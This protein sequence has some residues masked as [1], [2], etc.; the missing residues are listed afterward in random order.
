LSP[1]VAE[2]TVKTIDGGFEA[3]CIINV[4]VP[5]TGIKIDKSEAAVIAGENLKLT[6]TIIPEE[7]TNKKVTW[8]SSNPEAA[9]VDNSGLVTALKGGN[10]VITATAEDGGHMAEC[11]VTVIVPITDIRL[12]TQYLTVKPG[13]IL[14]LTVTITPS[15]A[16]RHYWL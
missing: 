16:E 12:N 10:T 13:E 5:V 4:T 11:M 3:K 1:G 15:N 2:I 6:A 8:V 9:I 14:P 7:A